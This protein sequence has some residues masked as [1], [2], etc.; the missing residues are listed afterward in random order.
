MIIITEEQIDIIG[1]ASKTA[2]MKALF[3]GEAVKFMIE[4]EEGIRQITAM[5]SGVDQ[6]DGSHENWLLKGFIPSANGSN[7]R[8]FKAYFNS[9]RR[10]GWI[11]FLQ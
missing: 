6:E 11:H 2:L 5:I 3:N 10:K 8:H 1:G 7:P 4:P 9:Q